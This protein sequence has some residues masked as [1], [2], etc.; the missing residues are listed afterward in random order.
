MNREVPG[1]ELVGTTL[2]D[3]NLGPEAEARM[4]AALHQV[5]VAGKP[6]SYEVEAA[7]AEEDDT[8]WYVSRWSPIERD[9]E[10]VAGLV[11]ASDITRRV[12]LERLDMSES[13]VTEE[14]LDEASWGVPVAAK[15]QT[16]LGLTTT[17]R[18]NQ[19]NLVEVH[20]AERTPEMEVIVDMNAPEQNAPGAGVVDHRKAELD[21]MLSPELAALVKEG[22]IRLIN[23]E[24]L[25]ARAGGP[26]RMRMPAPRRGMA[27]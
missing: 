16:V 9:G 12:M 25:I 21:A 23:Y 2:F 8:V 6:M 19:P 7:G 18:P 1:Q 17:A 26:G 22:K 10:V 13:Q 24:Q 15:K 3:H 27:P 20:V 4:R 5:F 14:T 11:V